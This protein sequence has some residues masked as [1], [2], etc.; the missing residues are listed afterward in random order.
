MRFLRYGP[1]AMAKRRSG[2][3]RSSFPGQEP[4]DALLALAQPLLTSE[5]PLDAEVF[6]SALAT[7]W[8]PGPLAP[9]P[10]EQ[11]APLV[12][13]A[14]AA[15]HRPE[16]VAVLR[17]L[18][19]V[20]PQPDAT[21]AREAADTL[22][23]QGVPEPGWAEQA[24]KAAVREAWQMSH[25]LGDG[26]SVVLRCRYP[27]GHEHDL[28]VYIDHNLGT[29][30]KDAFVSPPVALEHLH[31]VAADEPDTTIEPLDPA[32]A[33]AR[34]GSALELTDVTFPPIETETWPAVRALLLARLATMPGGGSPPE[35]PE[36]GPQERERLV[37]E[38]L[39]APEGASWRG[40][41]HG[42]QVVSFLVDFRCD[43]GDGRPLR[44]SPAVVE[45]FLAD[46]FPRKVVASPGMVAKVP[47]VVRAWVRYAGRRTSLRPSYVE[48]TLDAVDEL[49]E[50][51]RRQVDDPTAWGPAK[52]AVQEMLAAGVDLTDPDAIDAYLHQGG[53]GPG[54]AVPALPLEPLERR[55]IPAGVWPRVEEIA[56]HCDR[57]CEQALDDSYVTLARR[58]TAKL[59]RKRPSPLG[60]GDTRIWAAGIL[61]ALGQVNFLFDPASR[62]HLSATG[63]AA[64]L[65]VRPGTAAAKAT[66]VREAVG[67]RDLDPEFTRPEVLSAFRW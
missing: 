63:L 28:L 34:V 8:Q 53:A 64:L 4:E 47:D 36:L 16:V 29:L 49:A 58:L 6:A 52:T 56:G 5:D 13:D 46:W 2:P 57:V 14:L 37:A 11:Q 44:W 35:R 23:A 27:G 32:D 51:L 55:G 67:L 42:E 50:E 20:L 31:E 54:A 1:G 21:R 17:G 41:E 25:V 19:A 45:I 39:A 9:Q 40:D 15:T 3:R 33:A 10:V 7:S 48:E 43:Y 62:P 59:A 38:F 24:G 65:D 18:A 26:D 61:Y 22:A 60:R 30:V 66:T 12:I